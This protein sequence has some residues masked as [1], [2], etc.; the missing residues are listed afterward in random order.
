[1]LTLHALE[2]WRRPHYQFFPLVVPGAAALAWRSCRR[3]G[4][5]TP[6]ARWP[7]LAW[8]GASWA[9]LAV[10]VLFESPWCG[11]VAVLSTLLASAYV[12]GG[13]RLVRAVLPAWGFL[14]LAVPLPRPLDAALISGL[15]DVVSAW[16]GHLLDMLHVEHVMSGNVVEIAGRRL[17]V[18]QAC[19]GI[20]SLMALLTAVLFYALWARPAWPKAVA[21][22]A[23]TVFWVLAGNAARV[24]TV[25]VLETRFGV[26]ASSGWRHELVGLV[27]F[28][29]MVALIASTSSLLSCAAFLPVPARWASSGLWSGLWGRGG[30]GPSGSGKAG[31]RTALP[32]LRRTWL[33]SPALG[34]AFGLLLLP[35]LLLPGPSWGDALADSGYY[36]EAFGGLG[37]GVLPARVGGFWRTGFRTEKRELFSTWGESSRVW[38][39]TAGP[40]DLAASLDYPFVGWHDLLVC[41]T[42]TGWRVTDRRVED[43]G[44]PVMLA[45]LVNNEGMFGHVIFGLFDRRGRPLTPPEVRDPLDVLTGRLRSRFLGELDD[46]APNALTHQ[47]Q[48]FMAKTGSPLNRTERER[49]RTLFA[50]AR[51]S[52]HRKA[53]GGRGVRP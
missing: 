27:V 43:D 20:Y 47:I 11:T 1:M 9:L 15:Q 39:Y 41:Y 53:F 12:L 45:D 4:P 50:Q 13:P 33:G 37:E 26:D 52:I 48:V 17:L 49:A 35:Q 36:R 10:A 24:V 21:L 31:E 14:W 51:E 3:L 30:R 44:V 6:G 22:L 16:A 23:A 19:S 25:V 29:A 5:L 34:V 18:D 32:R 42:G 38:Q 7:A 2:L 8:M 40:T 28:L 46:Q